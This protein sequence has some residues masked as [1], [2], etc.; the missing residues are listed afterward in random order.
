MNRE[1][2][3]GLENLKSWD[4]DPHRIYVASLSDD[5]DDEDD[6][7]N[8]RKQKQKQKEEEEEAEELFR[9]NSLV[10]NGLTP[11]SSLLLNTSNR[12]RNNR[13]GKGKQ[14]DD[15][16][17]GALILYQPLPTPTIGKGKE[18]ELDGGGR[19]GETRIERIRRE[20]SERRKE[21]EF[22]EFRRERERIEADDE[23]SEPLPPSRGDQ[24]G[25]M[26]L[27]DGGGVIEVE[28]E[29]EEEL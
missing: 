16:S 14:V 6:D 3:M 13:S 29:I 22:M 21:L 26:E 15:G 8:E 7:D 1:I 18:K 4:L 17:N 2:E 27:E 5:D 11:D 24:G 20:E 23:L 19:E 10:A 12:L 9:L 25:G 28:M